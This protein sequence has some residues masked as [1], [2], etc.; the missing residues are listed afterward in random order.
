MEILELVGFAM[1]CLGIFL[2]VFLAVVIA[3]W[4]VAI[5]AWDIVFGGYAS[6][7][8]KSKQ[9]ALCL[10]LLVWLYFVFQGGEFTIVA[11]LSAA[12]LCNGVL[13]WNFLKPAKK[14]GKKA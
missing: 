14:S 4:V 6:I 12:T 7:K 10:G 9:I 1:L 13:L 3:I 8:T 11:I 2:S 5:L